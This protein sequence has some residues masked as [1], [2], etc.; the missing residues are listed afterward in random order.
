[1]IQYVK[2]LG[3]NGSGKTYQ[4]ERLAESSNLF[5]F[6]PMQ[7]PCTSPEEADDIEKRQAFVFNW[8]ESFYDNRKSDRIIVTDRSFIC[9]AV[10]SDMFIANKKVARQYVNVALDAELE[11]KHRS[12]FVL[13]PVR[14]YTEREGKTSSLYKDMEKQKRIYEKYL[15]LGSKIGIKFLSSADEIVI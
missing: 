6:V 15:E 10:F 13:L 14:D 1:M 11:S 2:F 9:N 8:I 12:I 7:L 5:E 4:S 3:P